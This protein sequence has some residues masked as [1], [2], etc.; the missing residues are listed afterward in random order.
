MK[1]SC[2]IWALPIDEEV[3]V[4]RVAEMGFSCIDVRPP[5]FE[6]PEVVDATVR[7][8]LGVSCLAAS[9]GLP[10][11]ASLDLPASVPMPCI[12]YRG[13]TAAKRRWRGMP[14]LS[15]LWRSEPRIAGSA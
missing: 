7:V 12:W 5:A 15:A 1:I 3:A 8:G 2:C 9:F 4:P 13:P 10:E 14:P 6:R 11:G